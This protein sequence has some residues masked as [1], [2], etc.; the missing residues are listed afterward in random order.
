[1]ARSIFHRKK[2]DGERRARW[3]TPR[4]LVFTRVKISGLAEKPAQ[5]RRIA[6]KWPARCAFYAITAS[7]K[8]I[9][10]TWRDTTGGWTHC[11]QGFSARSCSI[12]RNGTGNGRRQHLDTMRCC[13]LWMVWL[14]HIN[15]LGRGQSII[16]T[17]CEWR[18]AMDCKSISRK[19][20][21]TPEFT[22]RFLFTCRRPT[23]HLALKKVTSRSLK[24][25]RRKSSRFPCIRSFRP[26]RRRV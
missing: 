20:R 23:K 2:T 12:W 5:S 14:H 11:K 10:T 6:K 1:M 21:L 4:R 3:V 25:S 17:W 26:R 16:F 22:I 13:H 24:R 15:H 9:T 8:S 19:P 18:I 7:Q